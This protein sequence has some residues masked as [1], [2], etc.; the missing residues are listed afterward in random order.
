MTSI[1]PFP[2]GLVP[3]PGQLSLSSESARHHAWHNW[4]PLLV[5]PIASI[6]CRSLIPA[7]VFMWLLSFAIFFGCKWLTLQRATTRHPWYTR[8]AY[9]FAWPGMDADGFLAGRAVRPPNLREWV[10]AGLVTSVGG[11]LLWCTLGLL[12]GVN[13]TIR[14]WLAMMGVVMMLHFGL[15]H[16]VALG[17]R[18]AGRDVKPLMQAPFLAGSLAEFWGRRW[19]TA[20]HELADDFVFRKLAHPLGASWATFAAFLVSGLVHDLV[21]S[22]PARGGFGL[23]TGYFLL[24]GAGVIFERSR[25]G[26]TLGLRN[27]WR[28]RVFAW[29]VT[30]VPS[31][32][33][34]HPPF[35]HNV[36]LPMLRVIGG[37]LS[38]L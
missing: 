8:C 36:I 16:L 11:I 4:L 21:I 3:P 31:I 24:Q 23:P 35:V 14:G 28:G 5:L 34:F 30:A 27:G 22:L 13:P 20:F 18:A 10:V 6:A 37:V 7:W 1:N 25:L 17:W 19:N 9:V 26:R 29:I 12:V 15:F 32:W 38:M 33:L 2:P